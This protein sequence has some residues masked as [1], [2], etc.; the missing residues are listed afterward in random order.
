M[1]GKYQ[2][3]STG[4]DTKESLKPLFGSVSSAKERWLI[5]DVSHASINH[6]GIFKSDI[7]AWDHTWSLGSLC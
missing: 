1:V 6:I 7:L 2:I 5:F 4:K 3:K